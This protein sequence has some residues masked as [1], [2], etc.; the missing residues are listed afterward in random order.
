MDVVPIVLTKR[1]GAAG[2]RLAGA[3][4]RVVDVHDAA[5]AFAAAC[6]ESMLVLVD[7]DA[8]A[9]VPAAALAAARRGTRP[10][11]LVVSSPFTNALDAAA[12][13]VVASARHA[14]G[15]AA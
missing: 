14:L 12:P 6:A 15:V 11:V 3:S 9:L 4:V 10:L 2:W 1:L 13:D 5:N 8:A 7:A